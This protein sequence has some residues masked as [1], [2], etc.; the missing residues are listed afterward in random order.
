MTYPIQ[1]YLQVSKNTLDFYAFIANRPAVMNWLMLVCL[2]L[3]LHRMHHVSNW[4][5]V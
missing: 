1:K 2:S 3:G 5:Y 4:L